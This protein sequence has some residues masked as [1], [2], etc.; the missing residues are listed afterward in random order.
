MAKYLAKGPLSLTFMIPLIDFTVE[1]GATSYVTNTH[2]YIWDT[3]NWEENKPYMRTFFNDNFIQPEVPL[4]DFACFYGNVL[5]AIMPNN[6]DTE[7]RG[8]AV[9]QR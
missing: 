7:S 2:N 9:V 5:H 4:G 3:A 6:T 8:A 1:N